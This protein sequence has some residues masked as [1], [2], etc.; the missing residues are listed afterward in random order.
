MCCRVSVSSHGSNRGVEAPLVGAS[1]GDVE[2]WS[3]ES[4]EGGKVLI[5][6]LSVCCCIPSSE[7]FS[8]ALGLSWGHCFIS[9]SLTSLGA[10]P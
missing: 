8:V 2:A 4:M 5:Q 9:C 6:D 10:N 1:G 7:G 3:W